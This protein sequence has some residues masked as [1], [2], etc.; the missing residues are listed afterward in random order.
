VAAPA[1]NLTCRI[2]WKANADLQSAMNLDLIAVFG[3]EPAEKMSAGQ[4]EKADKAVHWNEL[5]RYAGI[6]Q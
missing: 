3:E 5:T 4:S 1:G 6:W 2:E